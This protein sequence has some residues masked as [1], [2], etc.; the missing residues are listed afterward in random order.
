MKPLKNT[1]ALAS[2]ISTFKLEMCP[3]TQMPPLISLTENCKFLLRVITKPILNES[4]SE[5]LGAQLHMLTN[6]PV[7]MRD[8]RSNTFGATCNTTFW[9]RRTDGQGE[10]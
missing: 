8:Y 4:T 10:I 1:K 9:D 6:I 3:R 2:T 5:T 7:K